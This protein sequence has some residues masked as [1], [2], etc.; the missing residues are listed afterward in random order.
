MAIEYGITSDI[1]VDL[2]D[3]SP[4]QSRKF[5]DEV[6][7]KE[8]ADNIREIGLINPIVVRQLLNGRY[9]LLAGERRWRA[10]KAIPLPT[11]TANIREVDDFT[12]R[13]IVLSENVQRLDLTPVEEIG[14][15]ADYVDVLMCND[16]EYANIDRPPIERLGWM[17]MKLDSDRRNETDSFT[18]K[19]VGKIEKAFVSLP[20]PVN[21]RSFFNHD[22]KPYLK[23]DNEVKDV[24][25][26]KK[27]KK[28]Q[29]KALQKVKEKAPTEFKK[30]KE[31]GKARPFTELH[32]AVIE[33]LSSR[34]IES[35]AKR[36]K[37]P[38]HVPMNTLL[39]P[40]GKYRVI[41][42]DPPWQ[43]DNV[44]LGGA[45]EKHYKTLSLDEICALRD[46]NGRLIT[47]LPGENSVLFLWVTSPFLKEGFTVVD[48]WGFSYKTNF[49]WVKDRE[50]YGKL[51]SNNH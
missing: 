26:Q 39:F 50:T 11:I 23:M 25:I 31:T 14:A 32:E 16:E 44:G 24:A 29:A 19:F 6:T 10:V 45:A 35:V 37:I 41:Y 40:K 47:D 21:W 13:K 5:F 27:L 9:E 15:F 49:V 18:N 4:Y 38:V 33:E 7:I 46:E 12:A 42:A 20:R 34:E 17:L 48:L 1:Q 43:Y 36:I 22:L 2:I 28:T 3:P 30:I 8:L 51:G